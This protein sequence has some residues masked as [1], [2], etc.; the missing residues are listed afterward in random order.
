MFFRLPFLTASLSSQLQLDGLDFESTEV[1]LEESF[2]VLVLAILLA[3]E[4]VV[5]LLLESKR[6]DL[7][8]L[9]ER[10][11]RDLILEDI[12]DGRLDDR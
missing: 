2:G 12:R 6:L 10:E 5:S 1:Q 4:I 8:G 7:R 11:L 9:S 3:R